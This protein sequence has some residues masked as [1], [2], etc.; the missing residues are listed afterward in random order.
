MTSTP[1][2]TGT[3]P[4]VLDHLGKTFQT[5]AG[6]LEI[7]RDV[8]L[9]F[10]AGQTVAITGPSG[11]GK[12][13]L[14]Y[15]I[16]LLDAPTSGRIILFG[17]DVYRLSSGQQARFRNEKIG[18]IFQEHH[19]LPQCT[20]L[21]NVLLA[22]LPAGRVTSA[23]E[24]RARSLLDRVGLS[25][26]LSHRPAQLSG[27]ERQRVAICRAL[28]NAPRLILADEPTGNLDPATAEDIG[29]LLLELQ[30]EQQTI[31][32]CVTHS[33]SLAARFPQQLTLRA[34]QLVPVDGE[35]HVNR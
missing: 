8:S 3:D 23:V 31:L 12:S 24:D 26:R 9:S 11:C 33:Q 6:P 1:V 21:E 25:A 35:R 29:T 7:L 17:E 5:A 27:G 14:L 19:L 30:A 22:R 20:V 10:Q 2:A 16:G 28:L 34:G 13:T 15:A 18:F 4:L 32:L